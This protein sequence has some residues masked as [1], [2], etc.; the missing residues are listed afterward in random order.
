M[1]VGDWIGIFIIP[2]EE[3]KQSFPFPVLP[4]NQFII[5][6]EELKLRN[7]RT[8]FVGIAIDL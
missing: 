3:L 8:V 5:P 2:N 6:N 1:A 7:L 4:S